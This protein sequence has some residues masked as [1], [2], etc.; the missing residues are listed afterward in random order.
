MPFDSEGMFSR[1]HNWEDDRQNDID[2]V[3]DHMDEEDDNFADG[4]SQ[5][6]LKNGNSKMEGDLD[7]GNFR[8]RNVANGTNASDAVNRSQLEAEVSLSSE[9]LTGLINELIP[10]GDIKASLQSEN[11]QNWLLCNGQEV[12]RTDYEELFDLIG[13]NFGS[14]NGVTT[15]NV[16]DYRGKFLRGLGGNSA[17]DFYTAQAEGL[18]DHT[19]SYTA[20]TSHGSSG[21]GVPAYWSNGDVSN[22]KPTAT[23]TKASESNAL[24]GAS[25]HVTPENFAV[26]YF[27][28]AKSEE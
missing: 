1:L 19:H 21:A 27:I 9:T 17:A 6:F 2:I 14:G 28:K 22:G 11:H 12:S 5:C 3:T 26:N 10:I 13:E 15:F 18:P 7:V 24:Y 16:P 4:L 8:V 23:F 20:N 25:E